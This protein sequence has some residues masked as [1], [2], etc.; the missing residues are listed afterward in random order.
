MKKPYMKKYKQISKFTIWIVDGGYV[1]TNIDEEFTNF[2][3]HYR[4]KFI[5]K[6]EFWIDEDQTHEEMRYFIDHM[7]VE[8]RIMAKG[9][10]YDLAYS[11]ADAV[12]K[13]ERRKSIF[14]KKLM[15]KKVRRL[16]AEKIHKKL[17]ETL[18]G[19]VNVWLVNGELVRTLLFLDFV[20]GGHDK[21]Y[22]F[23]PKGEVWIDDDLEPRERRYVLLHE[24][25]ER[26]LMSKGW[27][28][29][30][31]GRSAHLESSKIEYHCRHH[32]KEI[33]KY[34]KIEIKRTVK[35]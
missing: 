33:N 24:L 28:Y 11:R 34:L 26:Y 4:F 19:G 22:R 2:G 9:E 15:E 3:Q 18:S 29:Y 25:H 20:E 21:V 7:L 5:P 30:T 16:I 35:V 13:K 8:N 6:N 17:L 1:R 32:P 31:K 14:I 12:E 27:P 23:I 10:A